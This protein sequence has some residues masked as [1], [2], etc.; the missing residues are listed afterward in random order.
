MKLKVICHMGRCLQFSWKC[1][2][3][4]HQRLTNIVWEV[5][6]WVMK[7]PCLSLISCNTLL[8]PRNP[9]MENINCNQLLCSLLPLILQIVPVHKDSSTKIKVNVVHSQFVID[10]ASYPWNTM[11]KQ[12]MLKY[13]ACSAPTGA[14]IERVDHSSYWDLW[15]R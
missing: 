1:L 14:L 7:L 6:Y 15:M 10:L 11:L 2:C 3:V 8:T 5:A 13:N 9:N 12:N 4:C